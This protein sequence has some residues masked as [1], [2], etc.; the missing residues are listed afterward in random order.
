[1]YEYKILRQVLSSNTATLK[2]KD[3]MYELWGTQ[4]S[5]S[6]QSSQ[7]YVLEKYK[8]H[9]IEIISVVW[10]IINQRNKVES[11]DRQIKH[12]R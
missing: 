3:S 11:F 5:P 7:N 8:T 2:V 1:M 10:L 9:M 4:S 12:L 6:H